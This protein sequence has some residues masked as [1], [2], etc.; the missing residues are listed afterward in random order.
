MNLP[1]EKK[2]EPS[3]TPDRK[4]RGMHN[5]TGYIS[6]TT[7]AMKQPRTDTQLYFSLYQ[8]PME[9]LIAMKK[10]SIVEFERYCK[11]VNPKTYLISTDDQRFDASDGTVVA[12]SRYDFMLI[13]LRPTSICFKNGK[14][15]VEFRRVKHIEIKK[16][17][18]IGIDFTIVC[19]DNSN[20]RY[21]MIAY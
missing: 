11:A 16:E 15:F 21:T 4:R 20:K 17:S 5:D 19:G 6:T 1:Y 2:V 8:E 9:E 10:M 7:K 12:S 3:P 18:E 14:S 13:T